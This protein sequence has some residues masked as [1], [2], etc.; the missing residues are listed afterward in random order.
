VRVDSLGY[1]GY[2]TSPRFDSLLAKLVVHS[3]VGRLPGR[4]R[5]AYRALCELKVEGVA[6][7]VGFLQ[8]LLRHPRVTAYEV[9][10]GFVEAHAA[11]LVAGAQDGHRRCSSEP[12]GDRDRRQP[13]RRARVDPT[14][15]LAVLAHGKS[16]ARTR[17][18]ARGTTRTTMGRRAASRSAPDAGTIVAI[19]VTTATSSR[20]ARRSSS[21]KP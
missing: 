4:R 20:R 13:Y 12:D 15:P 8:A 18:A 7:N 17:R 1:A 6:T 5:R 3:A 11:E 21:W 2:T 10:T 16:V 19:E 14:D 9:D